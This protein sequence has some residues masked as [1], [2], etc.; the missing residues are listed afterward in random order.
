MIISFDDQ[1]VFVTG[2]GRGIGK[3]IAASFEEAGG[4]IIAPTRGE[5]DLKN[6]V[7]VDNYLIHNNSE[8]SIIV[9]NAGINIKAPLE[10]IQNH[11]ILDNFQVN[12]FSS[13]QI[14][15]K[16]VPNMKKKRQGKII[17]ISSLYAL[18][19]KENRILY[20]S[21]KNAITGLIKTL[22]LELS[23]YNI[24]INAVAPGYVMTEMTKQNLTD[25]E[26][27]EITEMIPTKRLQTEEEIA[28]LVL[29]LSSNLNQSITGQL[30]A[31]DGGFLCK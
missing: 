14:L 23:P 12:L 21:S 31:V 15:K 2:A 11:Q 28:D 10:E 20:S 27:M 24:L 18:V 3:A 6:P 4:K 17:F 13:I 9:L 16:F 7:S 25:E 8:P 22:S 1:Q 26:I 29:F 5:M 30:I 19:S